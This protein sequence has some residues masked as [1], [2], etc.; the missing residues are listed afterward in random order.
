MWLQSNRTRTE[1]TEPILDCRFR[2]CIARWQRVNGH[3]AC[4]RACCTRASARLEEPGAAL[5]TRPEDLKAVR[6]K[7]RWQVVRYHAGWSQAKRVAMPPGRKHQSGQCKFAAGVHQTGRVAR[8]MR[9]NGDTK[10][11]QP[12]VASHRE[13]LRSCIGK[14]AAWINEVGWQGCAK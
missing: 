2:C 12:H 11:S 8:A 9:G 5:R 10:S 3:A 13:L 4:E 14:V 1:I 7:I 6:M